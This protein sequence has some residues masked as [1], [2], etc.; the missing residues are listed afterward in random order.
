V[1]KS[2]GWQWQQTR[3]TDPA[4]VARDWLVLAVATFWVIAYGTRVE[5]AERY[6]VAPGR[7]RTPP[8]PLINPYPRRVSIFQQGL[9][10]LQRLLLQG[11]W[12]RRWWLAPEPWPD[13]PSGLV[14]FVLEES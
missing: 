1:L 8:A 7:R 9:Q 11:R 3:R 4:R 12:W 5:E 2:V 14:I 6:G 13:P 10:C